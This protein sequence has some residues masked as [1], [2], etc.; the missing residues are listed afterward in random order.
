MHRFGVAM[1]PWLIEYCRPKI[2]DSE[3]LCIGESRVLEMNWYWEV[4]SVGILTLVTRALS[5]KR[6]M[7]FLFSHD[8]HLLFQLDDETGADKKPV[9]VSHLIAHSCSFNT[10][11]PKLIA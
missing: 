9:P 1:L 7:P 5:E 6:K 10:D 11:H 2:T 8:D 3:G 4:T